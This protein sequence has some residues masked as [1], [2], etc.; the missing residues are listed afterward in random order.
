M[1]YKVVVGY[2]RK[3]YAHSI[4]FYAIWILTMI[5]NYQI[6]NKRTQ[7]TCLSIYLCLLAAFL[8]TVH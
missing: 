5:M 6:K 4:T 3:P 1:E 2:G 7:K 8:N